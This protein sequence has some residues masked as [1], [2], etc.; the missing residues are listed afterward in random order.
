M[1]RGIFC[2]TLDICPTHADHA[3]RRLKQSLVQHL[4]SSTAVADEIGRHMLTY[5]RRVPLAEMIACINDVDAKTLS[6][7]ARRLFLNKDAAV[8]TIG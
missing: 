2:I 3:R 5:G 6:Q 1:K 4:D 7:P 8:V